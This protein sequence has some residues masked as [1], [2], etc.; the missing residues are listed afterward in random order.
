MGA[1]SYWGRAAK[2]RVDWEPALL[3]TRYTDRSPRRRVTP[4]RPS[5]IGASRLASVRPN[6]GRSPRMVSSI[7]PDVLL[8]AAI[9]GGDRRA[10]GQLYDRHIGAMLA[11]GARLLGTSEAA[12][13]LAHDVLL[14][15]WR[16]ADAYEATRGSVRAW[17]LIR[18]R[19]RALDQLRSARVKRE[20]V[21]DVTPDRAI[22]NGED[23][24][25]S[26][27]RRRVA[28]CLAELPSE[29]RAVLE[30]GYFEGKSSSEIASD[31]DVPIGTVKSRVA[32][33]L[34]KLRVALEGG[35]A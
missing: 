4:T 28:R 8:M 13:D 19:S 2:T 17:L 5:L 33:G 26:P 32:A 22:Q 7:D 14:E 3:P 30:L 20:V 16:R 9:A 35:G 24:A 34:R 18:M 29:Q 31:L 1:A 21:T 27:D 10:L 25:L 6:G 23:P 12:E 15:A 11:V